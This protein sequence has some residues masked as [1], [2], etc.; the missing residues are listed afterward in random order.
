MSV[1]K[2]HGKWTIAAAEIRS[3]SEG[4]AGQVLQR[5]RLPGAELHRQ[6]RSAREPVPVITLP[7]VLGVHPVATF[8]QWRETEIRIGTKTPC[9]VVAWVFPEKLLDTGNNGCLPWQ[10]W[11]RRIKSPRIKQF[12]SV[13]LCMI[14]YVLSALC[15]WCEFSGPVLQLHITI[16]LVPEYLHARGRGHPLPYCLGSRLEGC[17]LLSMESL[18]SCCLNLSLTKLWHV[19]Q[20]MWLIVVVI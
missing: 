11:L 3:R 14:F 7:C 4:H 8:P 10:P 19:A 17:S 18:V 16:V 6:G 13:R 15:F 12:S 1:T 5:G 20:T 9:V 2:F